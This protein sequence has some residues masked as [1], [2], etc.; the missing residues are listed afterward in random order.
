[1]Q[2]KSMDDAWNLLCKLSIEAEIKRFTS[3]KT[4]TDPELELRELSF[5]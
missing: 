4:V 5:N 1:M 3:T 2:M